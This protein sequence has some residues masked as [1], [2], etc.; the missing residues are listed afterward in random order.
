MQLLSFSPKFS[1]IYFIFAYIQLSVLYHADDV[2]IKIYVTG[3]TLRQLFGG[4]RLV[5]SHDVENPC[6]LWYSF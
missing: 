5:T 2:S 6:A 4:Y 1:A 3:S